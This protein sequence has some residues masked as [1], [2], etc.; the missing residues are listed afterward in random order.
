MYLQDSK[1]FTLFKHYATVL[2]SIETENRY[3]ILNGQGMPL[4][5]LREHSDCCNR[6]MLSASRPFTATMTD[7]LGNTVLVIERDYPCH[8]CWI[9]IC[10]NVSFFNYQ[11]L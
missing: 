7:F 5:Q 11:P 6:Q 2:T 4:Y 9:P 1:Q 3:K 8:C 10:P